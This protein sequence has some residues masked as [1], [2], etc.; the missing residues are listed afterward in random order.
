VTWF[1][2]LNA[3]VGKEF[4]RYVLDHPGF[5]AK[6]PRIA[7]VVCSSPTIRSSTPGCGGWRASSASRAS[8]W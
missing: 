7:Q 2:A 4:D 6:I 8:P 5:A 1:E 3:E